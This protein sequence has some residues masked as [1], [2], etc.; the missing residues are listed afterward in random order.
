VTID[1]AVVEDW[2]DGVGEADAPVFFTITV[3]VV[4]AL[5]SV[6]AA[7][8]LFVQSALVLLTRRFPGTAPFQHHQ[9]NDDTEKSSESF[10]IT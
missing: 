1:A 9:C 3:T 6:V 2:L 5:G 10:S 8:A 7:N 4:A